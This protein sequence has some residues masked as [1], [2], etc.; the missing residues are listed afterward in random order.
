MIVAKLT[1]SYDRGTV[2]NKAKDLGAAL[3]KGD[4]AADGGVVRGLGSRFRSQDA[5]L[6]AKDR[7][8]EAHRV[9]SAF[10][11]RFMTTTIDGLYIVPAYGVARDFVDGLKPQGIE[12]SVSEFELTSNTGLDTEELAAWGSR[13][14]RQLSSV[15]L[16]RKKNQLDES[17]VK[18]V[19]ALAECP[20]LTAKTQ[21]AV[22]NLV[23]L[24]E[25]SQINRGDFRKR[26]DGLNIEIKQI[27]KAHDAQAAK[28]EKGLAWAGEAV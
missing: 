12:V 11:M 14:K 25:S 8:Q 18:A 1:I 3:N 16:G 13:V 10:R 26:L 28:V 4:V 9:Y 19:K 23:S 2:I 22:K 24:L 21:D 15:S 17:G 7:D 20:L 27:D 6:A 5:M